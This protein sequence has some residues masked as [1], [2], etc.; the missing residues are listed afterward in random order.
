MVRD[1]E[2]YTMP[3]GSLTF[4]GSQFHWNPFTQNLIQ[5]PQQIMNHS[6]D[7]FYIHVEENPRN[8]IP[9]NFSKIGKFN[10]QKLAITSLN[11]YT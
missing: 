2:F 5:Y 3:V 10:T 9:Q 6:L 7:S 1:D 4:V 8:Y 11:N